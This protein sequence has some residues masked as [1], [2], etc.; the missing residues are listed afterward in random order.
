MCLGCLSSPLCPLIS[1]KWILF[2]RFNL[3]VSP[4]NAAAGGGAACFWGL[5]NQAFFFLARCQ[6]SRLRICHQTYC[7]LAENKY[8][9]QNVLR[10]PLEREG[11]HAGFVQTILIYGKELP[12]ESLYNQ[13]SLFLMGGV[14]GRLRASRRSW[15]CP[16]V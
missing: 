9:I 1:R 11:S 5:I 16:L 15:I 3:C 2:L 7:Y 6:R 4:P 10:Y 14:L 8:T 13:T 12:Q